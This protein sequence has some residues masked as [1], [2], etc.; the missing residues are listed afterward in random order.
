MISNPTIL[1]YPEQELLWEGRKVLGE[2]LGQLFDESIE[3]EEIDREIAIKSKQERRKISILYDMFRHTS[4]FWRLIYS[5]S[6]IETISSLSKLNSC[7]F[8]PSNHCVFRMDIPG[9]DKH[10]FGWHQDYPYNMLGFNALTLW[11]PLNEISIDMGPVVFYQK[12]V[13][14]IL[15]VS[16]TNKFNGNPNAFVDSTTAQKLESNK[17]CFP[18]KF[19]DC[20]VFDA[21]TPHRSGVNLS[22]KARLTI[23]GRY[24]SIKDC[25]LKNQ[26]FSHR[27]LP[28]F[29]LFCKL[30]DDK[31]VR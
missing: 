6:V 15:P 29:D 23:Q 8:V 17:T 26:G 24:T 9:E 25:F 7:D 31:I 2:L 11:L 4:I 13:E 21:L 1:K 3:Y 18:L 20:V 5:E 28:N 30:H 10:V 19:G 14:E 16:F 27:V 12:A 22:D